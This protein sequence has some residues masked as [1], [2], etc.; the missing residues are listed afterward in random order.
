MRISVNILFQEE[1]E[2]N[3]VDQKNENDEGNEILENRVERIKNDAWR[4]CLPNSLH[5]N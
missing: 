3:E 5:T 2:E 1:D 4:F